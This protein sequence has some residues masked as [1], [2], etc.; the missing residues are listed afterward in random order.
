MRT[1]ELVRPRRTSGWPSWEELDSAESPGA[2]DQVVAR[3]DPA[4]QVKKETDAKL[5]FDVRRVHLFDP[6]TGENLTLSPS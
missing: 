4:S 5:W 2:A 1:S 3:L 6:D